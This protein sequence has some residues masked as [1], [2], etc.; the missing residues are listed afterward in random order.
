[1]LVAHDNAANN[2][3]CCVVELL[4]ILLDLQMAS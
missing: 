4:G 2:N 3:A 1:M